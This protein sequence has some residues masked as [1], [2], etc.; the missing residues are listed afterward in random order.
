M[1]S[2]RADRQAAAEAEFEEAFE[3]LTD[4]EILW[5]IYESQMEATR[6]LRT[7]S[8]AAGILIVMFLLSVIGWVLAAAVAFSS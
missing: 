6:Y 3:D 4:K 8:I 2:T 1:A 5:A 7:C